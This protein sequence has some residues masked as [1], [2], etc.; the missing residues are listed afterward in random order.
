MDISYVLEN[1]SLG[2]TSVLTLYLVM[3]P[4]IHVAQSTV[5]CLFQGATCSTGPPNFKRIAK[6]SQFTPE[7][8]LLGIRC[9][10]HLLTLLDIAT[11]KYKYI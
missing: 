7:A 5:H 9:S 2:F 1:K 4:C 8:A 3:G 11:I 10:T 6:Y